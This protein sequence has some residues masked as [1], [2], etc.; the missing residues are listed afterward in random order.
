MRIAVDAFGT[1]NAPFPEIEGAVLAI[2]EDLCE[3]VILVGNEEKIKYELEKFFYPPKRISV[4]NATQRI[5][6][7]DSA[8]TAVRSKRDSSLVKTVELHNQGLADAAVSAG[9]TGAVMSASLLIYGRI[10]NVLRPAIAV[11]FPTETGHQILLDMGANVDCTAENLV[12]FAKLG[13]MYFKYFFQEKYPRISLLNIGEERAKGNATT[14]QAYQLLSQEKELNFIGNIEGKDI[15]KGITDVV[16]CDGFVGNI[17]LKTIEGVGFSIFEILK[18]Q[19][20]KDWIAKLGA[21][22]SYPVYTHIKNKLDHTEYGGALL[23]GL[24]GISVV[25]HGRS[26]AKA[27]KNAIR[28]AALIAQSGFVTNARNYF[29]RT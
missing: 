28:F 6:M 15:I 18:E 23:V 27:M 17:V 19:I 21:L 9:N 10:K 25:A 8:V 3:E 13:S 22:L 20:N 16:V 7:E 4:V 2:K 26:N 29:E 1:D 12:Q 24:N 5:E 11:V 14:R